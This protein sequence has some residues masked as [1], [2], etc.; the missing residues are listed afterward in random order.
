MGVFYV[1]LLKD[2]IILTINFSI[3]I[4]AFGIAM[5]GEIKL[6][7][8]IQNDAVGLCFSR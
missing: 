7:D 2:S 6:T 1:R 5:L 8:G 3:C 4:F